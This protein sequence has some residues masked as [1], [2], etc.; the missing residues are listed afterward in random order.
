MEL[1]SAKAGTGR[2]EFLC[3]KS[4]FYDA[5][6]DPTVPKSNDRIYWCGRTKTCLGPDGQTVDEYNCNPARS[7]YRPF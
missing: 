4:M 3:W 6:D 5:V 2:C 7:C 1:S